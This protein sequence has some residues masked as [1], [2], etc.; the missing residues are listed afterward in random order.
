[1]C[2]WCCSSCFL[3]ARRIVIRPSASRWSASARTRA[4][5]MRSARRCIAVWSTVYTIAAA[6]SGI[7]GALFTQTNA[8]VTLTVFDFETSGQD[9]DH[10]DP[11]RHRTAL[12]RLRSAP[13]STWCWRT[14]SPS[15]RRRSGSSASVCCWCCGDVLRAAVCSAL[16]EDVG[17]AVQPEDRSHDDARPRDRDLNKNFG[18]LQVT[19][20]VNLQL[21]KRRAPRPDRTERRRQ[22]DP[23]QSD[24]RRHS[25][26]V[27]HASGST[28]RTSRASSRPR[29]SAAASPAPFRSINCSAA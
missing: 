15:C 29:A 6:M 21:D 3:I 13:W 28:A 9:H 8:Y 12:R 22:D 25:A 7:A 4:A 1:M 16:F 17:R 26:D 5:C 20:D 11:R 18:A 19:R 10:A 2:W 27:R 23:G 24:H 14:T